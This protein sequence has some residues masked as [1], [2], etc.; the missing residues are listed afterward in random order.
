M[1]RGVRAGFRAVLVLALAAVAYLLITFVQV[2]VAARTDEARRAD[3]IIVMGAAQFDGRP[4]P[5][6]RARL[7]HAADLYHRGLAPVIV[8][9]GGKRPGDRYTEASAARDYLHDQHGVPES[10][11]RRE[12]TSENT[13]QSM[14]AAA[15]FLRTE[16]VHEVLLVTDPFHAMRAEG[17]AKEVGFEAHTSPTR[18]SPIQGRTELRLMAREAAIVAV[19]RVVGYGRLM[20]LDERVGRVRTGA[21]SG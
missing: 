3:A 15:R 10:A 18:T 2:Y 9:T 11:F 19:G 13:W 20:R 8:V 1:R 4:S 7:D 16:G 6:F 5:V 17:V 12:T 14:A 21:G